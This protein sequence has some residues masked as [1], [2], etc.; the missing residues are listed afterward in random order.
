MGRPIKDGLDYFP[1]DT[2]NDDKLDLIEAKFGLTGYAVIIKLWCRAYKEYGYYYPW[3]EDEQILFSRGINVNINLVIDIIKYAIIKKLFDAEKL[4]IGVLTSRGMQK[5]YIEA[6]KRRH[7]ISFFLDI[8]LVN[9]DIIPVN[10][11]NK[12]RRVVLNAYKSTHIE[13]ETEIETEIEIK[14]KEEKTPDPLPAEAGSLALLVYDLHSANIA[15]MKIP[16]EAQL[17]Q[18]A[19][20]IDKLNRIDGRS[21]EDIER[22]IRHVK[23]PGNFWAPNIM[24]GSKLREKF[25]TI[26]AQMT[27]AKTC[28]AIDRPFLDLPEA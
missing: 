15:K 22:V 5:R 13:I 26:F 1:L 18:W 19:D 20:S 8:L 28:K 2:E 27:A 23:T 24:S 16:S 10:V 7:E 25:D 21:W 4:K 11:G 6:S 9:A 12:P 14:K 3:G 17:R